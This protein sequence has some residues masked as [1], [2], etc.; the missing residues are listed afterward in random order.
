MKRVKMK[1]LLKSIKKGKTRVGRGMSSGHGK[2]STRGMN[3]QKSRTGSSTKFF[4]GGQTKLINRIPK[5]RGFKSHTKKNLTLTSDEITKNFK[6]G[7]VV[8]REKIIEKLQLSRADLLKIKSFKIIKGKIT[9]SQIS[10]ADDILLS[11]SIKQ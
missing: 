1:I 5:A 4:E 3:G 8:S 6:P 7:E 11:K 10:F 9:L 2:T